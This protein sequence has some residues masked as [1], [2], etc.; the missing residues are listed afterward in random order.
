MTEKRSALAR[1]QK[2]GRALFLS[3]TSLTPLLFRLPSPVIESLT[4]AWFD[5]VCHQGILKFLKFELVLFPLGSSTE[6]KF[7]WF[8]HSHSLNHPPT[9]VYFGYF[10]KQI[11]PRFLRSWCIERT[12]EFT[13]T[14]W[15]EWI[16]LFSKEMQNPYLD[17]RFHYWIPQRYALSADI[18]QQSDL[19]H[20]SLLE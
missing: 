13:Q 5:S 15:S 1:R 8:T 18:V 16:H 17:F 9:V 14:L 10:T 20:K 2:N 4:L 3:L 7:Q 12:D 11:N 19:V 6:V